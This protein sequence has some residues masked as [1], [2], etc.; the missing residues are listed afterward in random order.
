MRL[1]QRLASAVML[2][3]APFAVASVLGASGSRYW[4]CDLA[5]HATA[6]CAQ[7]LLIVCALLAILRKRRGLLLILPFALL[8]SYRALPLWLDRGTT[9]SPSLDA[10]SEGTQGF[11]GIPRAPLRCAAI[12]LLVDN[13][14]YPAVLRA[15]TAMPLD[16]IVT[17]ELTERW[18][19]DLAP[20]RADFPHYVGRPA[21]VF[22]IGLWSRH[23][24]RTPAIIPLGVDWAPAI[25]AVVEA[26]QGAFA[27]LGV[28][29]PRASLLVRS[30]PTIATAHSRRSHWR[31]ATCLHRA[32]CSAI[33][34]R[35]AGPRP[36][37]TWSQRAA[38]WIP[39]MALGGSRPGRSHCL[40]ACASRSTKC[41]SNEACECAAAGLAPR[42]APTISQ[43]SWSWIWCREA[44]VPASAMTKR[45]PRKVAPRGYRGQPPAFG[46]ATSSSSGVHDALHSNSRSHSTTAVAQLS[47]NQ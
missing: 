2:A 39:P 28:H 7:A 47:P 33:A 22:G 17:S 29:T 40:H 5:A 23:P 38:S 3:A 18:A 12:N 41:W 14:D 9:L 8:A 46:T 34:M 31:S 13:T 20:L 27:V 1:G 6:Q 11:A 16:V 35:R 44:C 15:C 45:I 30:G 32:S 4:V 43:C 21:G 37:A 19:A 26:P 10:A 36:I 42:P 25:Q 24:L